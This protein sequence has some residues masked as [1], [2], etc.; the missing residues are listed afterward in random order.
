MKLQDFTEKK[1]N[2][3][4]CY[5]SGEFLIVQNDNG[6]WNAYKN[7]AAIEKILLRK[8]SYI[9]EHGAQK[10][11]NVLGAKE[12]QTPEAAAAICKA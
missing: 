10:T 11:T 2:G 4:S 6:M 12:Y 7:N 3:Y 1:I 8:D 5:E 9:D